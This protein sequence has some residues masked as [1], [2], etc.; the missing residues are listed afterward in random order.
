M[1]I[2]LKSAKLRIRNYFDFRR[3]IIFCSRRDYFRL[4]CINWYLSRLI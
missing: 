3:V 1:K 2:K 4:S